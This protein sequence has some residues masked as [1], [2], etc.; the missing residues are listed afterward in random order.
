MAEKCDN[1]D[2]RFDGFDIER[3]KKDFKSLAAELVNEEPIALKTEKDP[4]F[5][6]YNPTI[7]DFLARANTYEECNEIIDFCFAHNEISLEEAEKYR[8]V[9]EDSGPQ[10]FGDR[11]QGFYEDSR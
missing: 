11:K 1:D 2:E 4:T 9:L 6:N 5:K 3:L 8:K 10:I 7:I